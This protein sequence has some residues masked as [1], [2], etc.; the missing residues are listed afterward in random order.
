[1]KCPEARWHE[2]PLA[3]VSRTV[4]KPWLDWRNIHIGINEQTLEIQAAEFTTSDVGDAP[5]LPEQLD[6]IPPDQEVGSVTT[7]ARGAAAIIPL[8]RNAKPLKPVKPRL[9]LTGGIRV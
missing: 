4:A 7:P 6:Q 3:T 8:R 9:R 5:M 2:T 1:M